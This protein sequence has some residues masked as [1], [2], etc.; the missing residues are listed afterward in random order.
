[1]LSSRNRS[2][3][4]RA[5]LLLLLRRRGLGAGWS[6]LFSGLAAAHEEIAFALFFR[7]QGGGS[8]GDEG[9]GRHEEDE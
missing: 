6:L 1:M 4:G 5:L 3:D 8:A 9:L 7:A 2:T